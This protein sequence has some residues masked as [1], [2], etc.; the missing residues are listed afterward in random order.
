MPVGYNAAPDFIKERRMKGQ[1]MHEKSLQSLSCEYTN[2][3]AKIQ[4]GEATRG[5]Y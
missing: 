4:A 5:D 3:E 1:F 2:L